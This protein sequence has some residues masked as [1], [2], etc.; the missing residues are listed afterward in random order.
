M[1]TDVVGYLNSKGLR[2]KKATGAEV[3]LPCM[4]CNEPDDKRGRLYVNTDPEAEIPGLFK[5]FLCDAHGS[6]VSLKR[7]FGDATSQ[8]EHQDSGFVRQTILNAA[9]QYY[10][11]ALDDNLPALRYLVETRGL[12]PDT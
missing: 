2:F 1:S 11:D 6:L 3:N 9:T 7:H 8:E 4:F 10:V 5:C 12:Q